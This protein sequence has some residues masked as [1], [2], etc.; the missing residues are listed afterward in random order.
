MKKYFSKGVLVGII[1][2]PIGC[3]A[4][5]LWQKIN[6]NTLVWNLVPIFVFA[7]ILGVGL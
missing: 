1:T 5:G 3:L 7:I 4:A 2:I 6:I